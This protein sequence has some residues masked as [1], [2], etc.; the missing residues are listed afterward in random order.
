MKQLH[1]S[2]LKN[3]FFL[4]TTQKR[5]FKKNHT[6]DYIFH[7]NQNEN[8]NQENKIIIGYSMLFLHNSMHIVK[9][10]NIKLYLRGLHNPQHC[11]KIKVFYYP[12]E[13]GVLVFCCTL[14]KQQSRLAHTRSLWPQPTAHL[15][16][17]TALV[18]LS[19]PPAAS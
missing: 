7:Q 6:K 13:P 12:S 8:F 2:N 15:C 11:L 10:M 5:L 9:H 18:Q 19:T 17:A 4:I 3:C 14:T 16:L 1:V